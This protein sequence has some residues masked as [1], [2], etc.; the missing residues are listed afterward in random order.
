MKREVYQWR[1]LRLVLCPGDFVSEIFTSVRMLTH[2]GSVRA[3]ARLDVVEAR[4]ATRVRAP[5]TLG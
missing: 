3:D 5:Q 2:G 4:A 1:R